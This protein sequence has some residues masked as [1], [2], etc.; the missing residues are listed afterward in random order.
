MLIVKKFNN[1]EVS[2]QCVLFKIKINYQ[3]LCSFP[4]VFNETQNNDT[5]SGKFLLISNAAR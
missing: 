5:R 1:Y 2:A 4:L 3:S